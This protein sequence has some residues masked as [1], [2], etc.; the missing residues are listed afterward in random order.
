[1][2]RVFEDSQEVERVRKAH[3]VRRVVDILMRIFEISLLSWIL[4][5]ASLAIDTDNMTARYAVYTFTVLWIIF[6]DIIEIL[7]I[8][9]SRKGFIITNSKGKRYYVFDKDSLKIGDEDTVCTFGGFAPVYKRKFY[10]DKLAASRIQYIKRS[11]GHDSVV[12][13]DEDDFN[14]AMEDPSVHMI[15]TVK[16]CDI[17]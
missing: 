1:M 11:V 15:T 17:Q 10:I 13:V 6:A 16:I 12:T 14:K 4:S 8:Q 7:S 3:K 5:I 2:D 9:C